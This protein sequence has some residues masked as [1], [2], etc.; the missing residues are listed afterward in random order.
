MSTRQTRCIDCLAAGRVTPRAA[1]KAG[2]R[3]IECWRAEKRRRSGKA[4]AARLVKIYDL[5]PQEYQ[6]IY[7]AQNGRCAI[8]W[9]AT[10]ARKRLAVDHEH[11]KPGCDHLPDTGCPKCI[12]GL[13][14]TTCNH[15]V[16]GRYDIDAL[17]R[18]VQ[19]LKKPPARAVLQ[20][21]GRE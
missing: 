11:N 13:L 17:V 14:C 1:P 19:Y 15:V 3:C 18:A 8:C 6:A 2:P 16:I 10:G 9:R 20:R 12:R 4:A 7:L 21:E 5:S